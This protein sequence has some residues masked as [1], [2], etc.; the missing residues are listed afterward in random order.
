MVEGT[1]ITFTTA[2]AKFAGNYDAKAA[3][4]VRSSRN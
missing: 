3:G 2:S 4:R 1:I